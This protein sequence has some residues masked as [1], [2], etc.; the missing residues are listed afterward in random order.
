MKLILII[1]RGMKMNKSTFFGAVCLVI[2]LAGCHTTAQEKPVNSTSDSAYTVT[3]FADR[4]VTFADVPERIAVL[5]NGELDI[6]YALG[7]E[8]AGRPTG[9]QARL[10]QRQKKLFR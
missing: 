9:H 3:D 5:G 1:D 2:M 10:Y 7:E 8:V 6:V 4:D